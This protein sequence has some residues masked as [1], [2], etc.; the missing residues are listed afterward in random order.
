MLINI[1]LI[2]KYNLALNTE[3]KFLKVRLYK[4]T[5]SRDKSRV[6]QKEF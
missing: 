6:K 5:F 1:I 2:E 4:I 3:T